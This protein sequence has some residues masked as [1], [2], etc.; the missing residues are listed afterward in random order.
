[1]SGVERSG[2]GDGA[3]PRPVSAK[4][5]GT[6]AKIKV[7]RVELLQVVR[8]WRVSRSTSSSP[9]RDKRDSEGRLRILTVNRMYSLSACQFAAS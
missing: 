2:V 9:Q 6:D 5:P 3:R 1:M 7:R 4:S 8:K